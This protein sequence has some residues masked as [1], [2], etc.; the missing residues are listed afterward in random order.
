MDVLSFVGLLVGFAAI[1]GGNAME[2]GHL[3]ALINGPAFVI[4]FG[5]TFGAV[6]LQTPKN[7]FFRAFQI[8]PWVIKPPDSNLEIIRKQLVDWAYRSRKEG[9]LGLES[10]AETEHRY[11]PLSGRC[12]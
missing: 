3:G 1:I 4:V 6:M 2:G 8:L 10:I 7:V 9:L 5:G 12:K 11:T